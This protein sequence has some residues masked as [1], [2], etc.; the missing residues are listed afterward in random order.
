MEAHMITQPT[1]M[2]HMEA[3]M[4]TPPTAML[5]M[6]TYFTLVDCLS[7]NIEK[8]LKNFSFEST[9]ATEFDIT[10]SGLIV[11]CH[12]TITKETHKYLSKLITQFTK[13]KM[14]KVYPIIFII[15]SDEYEKKIFIKL[16]K[17]FKA[18]SPKMFFQQYIKSQFKTVLTDISSWILPKIIDIMNLPNELIVAVYQYISRNENGFD[19]NKKLY[20]YHMIKIF[21]N[22]AFD[23][24]DITNYCHSINLSIVTNTVD[25]KTIVKL[26]KYYLKGAVLTIIINK[27]CAFIDQST[28][29]EIYY[30]CRCEEIAKHILGKFYQNDKL[31]IDINNEE[32]INDIFIDFPSQKID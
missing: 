3:H 20:N 16:N 29:Y 32:L 14:Y 10:K 27:I 18:L 24:T 4:I 17:L 9:N 22:P 5:H 26:S 6:E 8:T 11:L 30:D 12:K 31:L 28:N 19:L 2:L 21:E 23:L 25:I 13:V 15:H 1:A 7:H